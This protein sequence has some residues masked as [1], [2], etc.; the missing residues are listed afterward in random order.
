MWKLIYEPL[1]G[2]FELRKIDSGSGAGAGGGAGGT[3]TSGTLT[4]P[5]GV[6]FEMVNGIATTGGSEILL[7][8]GSTITLL[9]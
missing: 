8:P 9:P 4:L 1:S 2:N 5:G 3:I 7:E 6:A